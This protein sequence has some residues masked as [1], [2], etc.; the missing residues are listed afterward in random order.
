MDDDQGYIC[1][2]GKSYDVKI[3]CRCLNEI[4]CSVDASLLTGQLDVAAAKYNS[5]SNKEIIER[6]EKQASKLITPESVKTLAELALKAAIKKPD[7]PPS[8]TK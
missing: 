5:D 8:G 3:A 1:A 6:F 4:G 7:P 2:I